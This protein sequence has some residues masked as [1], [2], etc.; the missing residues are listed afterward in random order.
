MRNR[1]H[2]FNLLKLDNGKGVIG[3]LVSLGAIYLE[4][5]SFGVAG[6]EKVKSRFKGNLKAGQFRIPAATNLGATQ[7]NSVETPEKVN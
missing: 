5:C 7:P 6:Y 3:E 2:R 1:N 4:G